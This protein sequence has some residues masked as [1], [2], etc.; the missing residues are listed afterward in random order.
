MTERIS[1]KK[2]LQNDEFGQYLPETMIFDRLSSSMIYENLNVKVWELCDYLMEHYPAEEYD[3]LQKALNCFFADPEEDILSGVSALREDVKSHS[4]SLVPRADKK[5]DY[6]NEETI[7][8]DLDML[9]GIL[10][11][12]VISENRERK[13]VKE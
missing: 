2:R 13:R 4:S 11:M 6:R 9:N 7:L 8:E 1:L 5:G 3:V 12:P 10:V